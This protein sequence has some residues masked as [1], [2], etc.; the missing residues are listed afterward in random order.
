MKKKYIKP[1]MQIIILENRQH[2]MANSLTIGG[3]VQIGYGG[4]TKGYKGEEGEEGEEE[5]KWDWD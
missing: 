5:W 1:S 4:G 3:D 2:I